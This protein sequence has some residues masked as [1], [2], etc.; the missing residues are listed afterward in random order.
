MQEV[1]KVMFSAETKL[2]LLFV[3]SESDVLSS[4]VPFFYFL[5]F[6]PLRVQGLHC[7]FCSLLQVFEEGWGGEV[8]TA[9]V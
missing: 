6:H 8:G 4:L 7:C 9:T 1:S 5:I 3:V 2:A